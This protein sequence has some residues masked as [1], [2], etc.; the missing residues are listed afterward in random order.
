[1]NQCFAHFV[2]LLPAIFFCCAMVLALATAALVA[3]LIGISSVVGLEE[4]RIA[5][6]FAEPGQMYYQNYRRRLRR[7][8]VSYA[9]R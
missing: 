5:V 9:I 4:L 1:M 8:E 6:L 3:D 2:L 7:E